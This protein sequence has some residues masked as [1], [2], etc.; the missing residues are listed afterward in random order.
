M[1]LPANANLDRASFER[2]VREH[3]AAVYAA[4]LRITRDDALARD[5]AQQTFLRVLEGKLDL[6]GAV[7]PQRWLRCAAAREALMV[8]R[9]ARN[10][11]RR[12]EQHAMERHEGFEDHGAELADTV[13]ALKRALEALPEDLRTALTLRFHEE[14]SYSELGE[15]L[16]ISEPSAHQRVQR[17]LEKL[18]ERLTRMG[19]AAH[20]PDFGPNLGPDFAGWLKRADVAHV[21]PAGLEAKLLTL[22]GAGKASSSSVVGAWLAGAALVSVAAAVGAWRAGWLGASSPAGAAT[23]NSDL[24][25]SSQGPAAATAI[26]GIRAETASERR[27]APVEPAPTS[28]QQPE[29]GAA[30]PNGVL[31]GRVVDEFGLPLEGVDVRASSI[32][33]HSKLAEF[34]GAAQTARDGFFRL[35]LPVAL[36]SGQDYALSATTPTYLHDAGVHRVRPGETSAPQRIQLAREVVERPGAWQ[37]WVTLRDEQGRPVPNA[38]ARVHW[39]ARNTDAVQ[40]WRQ[41]CAAHSEADGVATLLGEGL[42]RKVL[43]IDARDAGFAPHYESLEIDTPGAT[44]RAVVLERG[45]EIVGT[46]V[47]LNGA[48]ISRSQL[49]EW[50][51]PLYAT[52]IDRNVWY[53]AEFPEPG[54]FR[55]PALARGAHE[56]HFQHERWSSF[57]LLGVVPGEGELRLQL[58]LKDDSSD[59]GTHCAEIHGRLVDAASGAPVRNETLAT[60][61][62]RIPDDSPALADGD[63]APLVMESVMVQVAAGFAPQGDQPPAPPENAFVHD[64]LAAGRY[65]VRVRVRGYAP[66]LVGP[67]ELGEREIASG[68]HVRLL[69]GASVEGVLRD[70]SGAP[71]AGA[72]VLPLGAG[73]LSL[74]HVAQLDLDVRSSGGRGLV[75]TS[76]VQTDAHGRFSLANVPTDRALRLCAVHPEREPAHGAWLELREGHR[77]SV[78][79]R[80]G[81]PRE[82]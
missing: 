66:T 2:A 54:R 42:G 81:A 12:E 49:G 46:I 23:L 69:R 13:R 72:Y 15:V 45:A 4:A 35:S 30:L 1:S 17:G 20:A 52:C 26:D 78:E 58:K 43:A 44:Q 6:S 27:A 28:A 5:A 8:L 34:A 67:L 50:T 14:L 11:R 18:R 9:A 3:H 16:A 76:A 21:A 37:L 47:D 64:D 70:A 65:A 31:E 55:I 33:R 71:I 39:I 25:S 73:G 82:R 38:A 19:L 32:E 62:E 74:Q 40:W 77:A 29:A 80:A 60:W 10:R 48:P 7:D 24:A 56:L 63:F 68:I 51:T 57:T 36:D 22:G 59:L 79:L 53:S 61:L 41:Q 75:R